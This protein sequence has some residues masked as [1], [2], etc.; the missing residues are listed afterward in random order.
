[1]NL[2]QAI[3]NK[4]LK[5]NNRNKVI[6][7]YYKLY[8]N[9]EKLDIN[10]RNNNFFRFIKK[11]YLFNSYKLL[12]SELYSYKDYYSVLYAYKR[13]I[14]YINELSNSKQK[15]I[16]DFIRNVYYLSNCNNYLELYNKLLS[17]YSCFDIF[18]YSVYYVKMMYYITNNRY[19]GL[20]I[21]YCIKAIK[22]CYKLDNKYKKI[23]KLDLF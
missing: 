21:D 12:L 16:Y 19:Y 18:Q 23:T 6:N 10:R 13:I 15:V 14:F 11:Y 4:I 1:M 22:Y 8:K 2:I 9:N 7:Y 3:Y 17:N 20:N 5:Y